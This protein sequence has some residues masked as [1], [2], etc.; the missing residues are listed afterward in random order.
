MHSLSTLCLLSVGSDEWRCLDAHV[1]R[2]LY[3]G[4]ASL[5]RLQH[6]WLRRRRLQMQVVE[7][8][9]ELLKGLDLR[10]LG[11]DEGHDVTDIWALRPGDHVVVSNGA[12]YHHGIYVGRFEGLTRPCFA[13][14]GRR[15]GEAGPPQLRIA[16]YPEFMRGYSTYYIVGYAEAA[17]AG[18]QQEQLARDKAVEL[19]VKMAAGPVTQATVKYDVLGLNCE[20]FA[21]FCKTGGQNR[22][23]DQ[24][25]AILKQIEADIRDKNSKML[26]WLLFVLFLLVFIVSSYR[27]IYACP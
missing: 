13:D 22:T 11:A 17:A 18:A 27:R 12:V 5:K 3:S 2:C 21:W 25:A 4:V 16:E 6:T 14:M 20:C 1:Q 19:A 26:Q 23:S 8:L 9:V 24:V 15:A 10:P 7:M